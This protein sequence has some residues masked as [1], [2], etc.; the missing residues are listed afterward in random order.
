MNFA[1]LHI[2]LNHV[3]SIGTTVGVV[4]LIASF[5]K[6]SDRLQKLS[7]EIL[8]LMA[9]V[10]LP[11]YVSGNA[12]QQILRARTDIPKGLIEAHQNS[13]MLTLIL[14]IFTGTLAWFGLWQFRRF[15]RPGS[16]LS[17]ATLVFSILT[18]ALIL[19]TANLGGDISHPEI[20]SPGSSSISES[21]GWR[22]PVELF[23][24]QKSWVWPASE[25]LHFIGMALLFGI[26]LLLSL[27]MLGMMKSIPFAAVHRLLPLGVLGFVMNVISG[28]VFFIASPGMYV[29]NPGFAL[30]IGFMLIA[31]VCV[32]YFTVFEEPWAVGPDKD[33]PLTAKIVAVCTLSGL[34]G[35]MYFGRML[36]FLRY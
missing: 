22:E 29:T 10:A 30:K 11:T 26:V 18:A 32:I 5:Y 24:N 31:G 34:L 13:A 15:A 23:S 12:A 28:M 8:V 25:T 4:L 3:P 16:A 21:I 17:T 33:A 35:V 19:R 20:R 6:K 7:L 2:V 9:L 27:R 1:H 36:P 14:L